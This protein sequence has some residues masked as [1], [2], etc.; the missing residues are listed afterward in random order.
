M[1]G[2]MNEARLRYQEGHET[3]GQAKAVAWRYHT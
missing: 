2:A 3:A 1:D